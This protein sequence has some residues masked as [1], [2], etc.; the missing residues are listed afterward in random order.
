MNII[1]ISGLEKSYGSIKALD[2]LD[3]SVRRGEIYGFLGPN[4][5]GKTTTI[6]SMMGLIKPD[7]GEITINGKDVSEEGVE[8]RKH[9]GYLP[10]NL[11][12]YD[13]LTVEENLRFFS[14]LK[15]GS[16]SDV[17]EILGD[18]GLNGRV[19]SKVGSLS[20]GMVQRLGL[21]QTLIGDPPILILDEPTSGLDPEIRRWVKD[22][23]LELKSMDK[24]IF[25]SSH[26]LGEV[27]QMCD[28]VGIIS[29]GRAIR[30]DAV[31]V[32]QEEMKLNPRLTL[33][34]SDRNEID[35]ALKKINELDFVYRPR[36]EEGKLVLYCDGRRKIDVIKHL[37]DAGYE[38]DDFDVEEPDLEEMFVKIMEGER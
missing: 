13:R 34:L 6:K 16:P 19:N 29:R 8:L 25:L 30:E 4:G 24:T 31:E 38:I 2:G 21:V 14:K 7:D 27:Q 32:L 35:H 33:L 3:L 20:K 18:F 26:V 23:I 10:E 15:G 22:K 11:S 36:K 37:L 28:R 9:L 12:F 17:I 5:A 1:E